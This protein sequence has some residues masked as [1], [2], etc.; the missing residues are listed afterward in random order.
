MELP[1]VKN[2]KTGR[3]IRYEYIECSGV[4][5]YTIWDK[6][7]FLGRAVVVRHDPINPR[8]DGEEEIFLDIV[9]FDEADRRKGVGSD[10]MTFI[11]HNGLHKCLISSAY[12]GKGKNFAYKTGWKTHKSLKKNEPDIFYFRREDANK[13]S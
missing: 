10:L 8:I 12:S 13:P 11:T 2:S 7:K 9:I 5:N 4:Y 1:K 6:E 3:E